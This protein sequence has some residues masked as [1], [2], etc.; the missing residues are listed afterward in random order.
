[1]S[2]DGG[3]LSGDGKQTMQNLNDRLATY[4]DNVRELEEAN[5]ELETKIAE[6]YEKFG[7]GSRDGDQ[8][9]YSKYYAIIDDLKKQVRK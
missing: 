4:L 6:W 3:L 8:R 7:G 1:M 9:D 5:S 2:G